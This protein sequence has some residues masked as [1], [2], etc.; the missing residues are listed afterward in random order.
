VT[1]T[2]LALR[3][4]TGH[5]RLTGVL[6]SEWTKLRTVRSAQGLCLGFAVA[7][8]VTGVI[9]SGLQASQW[10]RGTPSA[11]TGFDPVN[12]SLATALTVGQLAVG[13]LG[14]LCMTDEYSSGMIRSS[15]AAVPSRPR[16]LTAKAG[17]LASV[18]LVAGE[19]VTFATFLAG[20]AV[21]RSGTA[22]HAALGQPGVL[23][24]VALSGSYLA[25]L[26]LL[27]LGIGIIVRNSAGAIAA[28][29]GIVLVLPLLL[30]AV[31]GHPAR[32]TPETMLTASVAAVRPQ[33]A[34]QA[35]PPGWDGL[36]LMTAYSAAVLVLGGVRFTRRDA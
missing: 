7:T 28:Y 18:T 15:L 25:L 5:Y 2:A 27:G 35:L 11:R 19:A 33:A 3:H 14:V 22:P 1:A 21:L 24:A 12:V 17:V 4:D 6:R 9:F 30:A 8:M 16:L 23:R 36:L 10:A 29:A 20:Q 32:F 26:A 13:V 31:P 34:S